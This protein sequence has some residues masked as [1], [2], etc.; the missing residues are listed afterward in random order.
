M[1]SWPKD[2]FPD[3][4]PQ[5]TPAEQQR[6]GD[7]EQLDRD[8]G[9]FVSLLREQF[10]HRIE[11]EETLLRKHGLPVPRRARDFSY[12]V[13]TEKH[14]VDVTPPKFDMPHYLA[15]TV[16]T[17]E[18]RPCE[19]GRWR[20]AKEYVPI[21]YC[22]VG[23]KRTVEAE[24]DV[25][26]RIGL[27]R[28]VLRAQG[29]WFSRNPYEVY[30]LLHF[31]FFEPG[32]YHKSGWSYEGVNATVRCL[33]GQSLYNATDDPEPLVTRQ[34]CKV[35]GY[36]LNELEQFERITDFYNGLD[37][38]KW[39]S[40]F[41]AEPP[42]AVDVIRPEQDFIPFDLF[43]SLK[44]PAPQFS[45]SPI[46]LR[47]LAATP[48][49]AGSML[50]F[51]NNLRSVK[52]PVA[53]EFI[54]NGSNAYFQ[55]TCDH[56]D[57]S[58]IE[59][60]FQICFPN[61]TLQITQEAGI[62]QELEGVITQPQHLYHE[63]KSLSEFSLDPFT[64][65]SALVR[66][67]PPTEKS[68]F[69]V[70]FFP[71][72]DETLHKIGSRRQGPIQKSILNK[73]PGWQVTIK[74]F[75]SSEQILET[76]RQEFLVQ[77]ARSDS[78]WDSA[79][80]PESPN[81]RAM[82]DWCLLSTS[83]LAAL[84]HLPT[85]ELD[86]DRLET[87]SMK[88]RLPPATFTQ[89]GISIGQSTGRGVTTDVRLPST[90]R[91]RHLYVVGK[92]GTGKSTLIF[93]AALQDIHNGAGVA[94]IDP[95]GDLVASGEHSLLH[96]IPETRLN[97]V[98]Y[99]NAADKEHPIGM[100]LMAVSN[101]EEL[102]LL[103]TNLQTTFRRLSDSWGERM[104]NLLRFSLH[105]LVQTPGSTFFDLKR[106]LQNADYRK[107]V[108]AQLTD[109]RL[110]DFWQNDFAGYKDSIQPII[111]RMGKF[112]LSPLYG[113]LSQPESKLNFFD[114]I[115]NRKILLVNLGGIGEDDAQLL[116]SLLVSQ[117]QLAVMQRSK[118]P[119]EYRHPYYLYVDEFQNFTSRAFAKILS[120]ARKYQLCLTL[121][122]QFISQLGESE[123]DAIFGNIGTMVMFGVGD[124]DAQTLR[125][126]LGKYE[127]LDLVNIP[128]YQALCRPEQANDTFL[129]TTN[130][131]PPRPQS[132]A[133][134]II[135]HT[136]RLYASKP[137]MPERPIV[138]PPEPVREQRKSVPTSGRPVENPPPV[139]TP[140]LV[141]TEDIA[142]VASPQLPT[143]VAPAETATTEMVPDLPPRPEVVGE[144]PALGRGG[145]Q[146][147]YLQ[148]LI[149]RLAEEKGYRVIIEQPVLSGI[150]SVDV[151][152]ERAGRKIACEISVS[153]TAD[154]ELQNIQ[155]CLAAGFDDVIVLSSEK[156]ALSKINK[157]VVAEFDSESQQRIHFFLPEEFVAFLEYS[158]VKEA[159]A[160]QTVRGYKVNVKF[161]SADDKEHKTQRQ[162]VAKVIL[163]AL[164]RMKKEK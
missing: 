82:L 78:P 156:R 34:L 96:Y 136:G 109:Y 108:V 115:H 39:K 99:L 120:E 21:C 42:F 73:V 68:V 54:D 107:G 26:Q 141:L 4:L 32:T 132:F 152:L 97:D 71:M 106:L 19:W 66:E 138:S 12:V 105:T 160:T 104:D 161:K 43:F 158:G 60:Q 144:V 86:L 135:D 148:N 114:V 151:S 103:A 159:S 14:G 38:Q 74:A 50:D 31:Y 35:P 36:T 140:P 128:K 163:Q 98:V 126:Q 119:P 65:L 113:M 80:N 24:K 91:D 37:I 90:V 95:H 77:F 61:A 49:K 51:L 87:A 46:S 92:S 57:Q 5:L 70:L 75:S 162:A 83:E 52:H 17:S 41:T 13:N 3:P 48:I 147:K 85:G 67:T 102:D 155:K 164:K 7:Y 28:L 20:L 124:K 62:T 133:E 15:V 16:P 129:L 9:A 134:T 122:H 63:T 29:C 127:P 25:F 154:Y 153:S 69:Q 76:L 111:S 11:A 149:K 94:V 131:P 10:W 112:M 55:L 123:R 33:T 117:L 53:F 23:D 64:R 40:A 47:I 157:K 79:D 1:S 8:G 18:V 59:R 93:N 30:E 146:H 72:P 121:A 130:P 84:A 88:Q 101:D 27:R 139:A 6:L 81:A 137:V 110:V 56:S 89:G 44:V 150:G 2:L 58:L 143:P 45:K 118:I 145:Q 125:H 100:N 142:H 116:G 22:V